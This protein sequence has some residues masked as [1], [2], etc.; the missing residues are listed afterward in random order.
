MVFKTIKHSKKELQTLTIEDLVEVAR[1]EHHL[2]LLLVSFLVFSSTFRLVQILWSDPC[3]TILW[4]WKSKQSRNSTHTCLCAW[5]DFTVSFFP[6]EEAAHARGDETKLKHSC[7]LHLRH[8]IFP[9][10]SEKITWQNCVVRTDASSTL[11]FNR[12]RKLI[13]ISC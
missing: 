11:A 8:A 7:E 9:L 10:T 4:C 12:L 2:L 3:K 5:P 13:R 1:E 6:S